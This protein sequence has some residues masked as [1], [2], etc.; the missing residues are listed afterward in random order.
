MY[1]TTSE[2]VVGTLD[3]LFITPKG[4]STAIRI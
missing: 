2:G 4:N 3:I 1:E